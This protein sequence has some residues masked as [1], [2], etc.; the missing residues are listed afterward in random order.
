MVTAEPHVSFLASEIPA[1]RT[2][3][4]AAQMI[5]PL[6]ARHRNN[7]LEK[8]TEMPAMQACDGRSTYTILDTSASRCIIGSHVLPKLLQRLPASVQNCLK[9][10]PSQIKFRFGNNQTLTSQRK[11]LFPFWSQVKG[12]G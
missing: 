12:S 8:I 7:S 11:V 2:R 4:Q 3:A 10:R 5:S 1:C 6:Q 9:E